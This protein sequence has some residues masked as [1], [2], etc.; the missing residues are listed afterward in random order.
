M[1]QYVQVSGA[2]CSSMNNQDLVD[3][4]KSRCR[5]SFAR[6][7][8]QYALKECIV[9]GST[10]TNPYNV[11]FKNSEIFIGFEGIHW[12]FGLLTTFGKTRV[13][14]SFTIEQAMCYLEGLDRVSER[15]AHRTSGYEKLLA[16]DIDFIAQNHSFFLEGAFNKVTSEL[17]NTEAV[18]RTF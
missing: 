4:F 18:L 12:G 13:N 1:P 6:L 15:D 3:L 16:L 2:L 17:N 14:G 11:K 5:A 9:C 8:N 10:Y 7:S